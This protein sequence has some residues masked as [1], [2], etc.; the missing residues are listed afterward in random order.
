MNARE[1]AVNIV[2]RVLYEGGY[3]SLLLRQI[4]KDCPKE[5]RGLISEIVYGTLRNRS[6]L[7]LQLKDLAKKRVRPKTAALLD[8]SLYQLYFMDRIPAYA[9]I[10]EAVRLAAKQEKGFVNA[11]LR[12][13]SERDPVQPREEGLEGI[14][15]RTSHPLFLLKL[16]SAQYG[17][18]T[19]KAIAEHD[20]LP[21][22]VYARRNPLKIGREA[23]EAA[24]F[25]FLEGECCVYEGDLLSSGYLERGEVIIQ[26]RASQMVA[27]LLDAKP[28]MKVLD[29]CAAP[30]T[31]TQQTA[32]LMNNEGQIHAHDLYPERI[33]LIDALMARTGV[34]IVKASV[35]DALTPLEKQGSYDRI[36]IDAPCSGLGDLS[37]KPEIRWH[38]TPESLDELV[39]LQKK[40]LEVNA[41]YLKPGGRLVYSTCTLNRKENEGMIAAF[42]KTHPDFSILSEKTVFPMEY[43]SD[44]FYMAALTR[45]L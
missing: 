41:P 38:V 4:P 26:D 31:K 2:Y 1:T 21:S 37:H 30:G 14:A 42:L 5:D 8:V 9:V 25:S 44:G 34:S 20:Q 17:E 22:K 33:K 18:E 11:V 24:G 13:A 39:A 29:V 6:L 12:R 35:H 40:I 45:T 27:P 32:C 10:D 3:A 16:W 28:G 43:D 7:E 36:L 15:V 23:L 19:A